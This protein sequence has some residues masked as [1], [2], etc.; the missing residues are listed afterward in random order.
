MRVD[1]NT[2]ALATPLAARKVRLGAV[3]LATAPISWRFSR[4]F[5]YYLIMFVGSVN[6]VCAYVVSAS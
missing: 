1:M 2:L 4:Y 6:L 3:A 5:C